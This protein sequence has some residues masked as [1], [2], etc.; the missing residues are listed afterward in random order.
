MLDGASLGILCLLRLG[1]SVLPCLATACQGASRGTNGQT[2]A[3]ITGNGTDDC[4]TSRTP[5]RTSEPFTTTDSR[6]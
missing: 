6:P 2:I 3:G 4:T 5:G 1:L